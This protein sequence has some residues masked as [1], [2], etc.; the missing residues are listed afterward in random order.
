LDGTL[1]F[2]LQAGSWLPELAL[3]GYAQSVPIR[4]GDYAQLSV[5]AALRY[6]QA[7]WWARGELAVNL[8][9]PAGFGETNR[10]PW[11][12]TVATGVRF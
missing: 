11:G 9:G 4:D 5:A 2:G 8:D 3:H 6:A 7:R 1:R 10:T 12:V